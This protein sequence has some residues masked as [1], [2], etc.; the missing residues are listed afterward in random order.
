MLDASEPS[1]PI[2]D[3][4][5]LSNVEALIVVLG[6]MLRTCALSN[7]GASALTLVSF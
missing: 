4:S 7:C 6:R 5:P 2:F 1:E 3:R